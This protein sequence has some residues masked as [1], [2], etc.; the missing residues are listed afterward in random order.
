M[1]APQ[2]S[3]KGEFLHYDLGTLSYAQAIVQPMPA[4]ANFFGAGVSS[5]VHV[6]GNVARA[7]VN[8]HF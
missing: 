4:G 7:G 3:L 2:W 5:T 6:S 8:F 1:F